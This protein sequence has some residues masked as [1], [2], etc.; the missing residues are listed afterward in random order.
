MIGNWISSSCFQKIESVM[1]I[2]SWTTTIRG[3]LLPKN[4]TAQ[5]Q[6]SLEDHLSSDRH[7][8]TINNEQTS[9]WEKHYWVV[10]VVVRTGGGGVFGGNI[11]A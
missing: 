4:F 9:I 2:E 1:L 5:Q 10:L 7:L 8:K 3:Q 11:T 6:A